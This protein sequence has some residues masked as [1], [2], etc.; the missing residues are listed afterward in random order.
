MTVGIDIGGTNT[1]GAIVGEDITTFKVP[2]ELGLG[3]ILKRICERID[4]KRERLVIST[5]LPLNLLLSRLEEYPTLTL[6]FPGPGLNYESYGVILKGAV[7][8]RGDVVE[9]LDEDQIREVL[10]SGKGRYKNVAIAGKFSIRNPLLELKTAKIV[11]DYYGYEDMALSFH[12]PELNYSLRINTTIVNAKIKRTVCELTKLIK[13]Y[14]EDFFYY[15]G[16]GGIVPYEIALDNPSLLYNSSPASVA[17][18]AYYLTGEKN[19]L[20]IDIGGTTTDFVQLVDG[21]PRIAEKV[22]VAGM[23][24]LIRCVES[25]SIPFGGD[26][27]V[28][29]G[30]L[31]PK[32]LDK[33]I[34]FGGEFFTLTDALNCMG[35]EI[36]DYRASREKG[37]EIFGDAGEVERIVEDYV[38][39]VAESVKATDCDRVIGTGYLARYLLPMIAKKAGVSYI[40]PEHSEAVNAIGVAV[41]RISLTM[42]ARFDTERGVAVFNGDVERF[43]KPFPEDEELIEIAKERVRS[44]AIK[45]GASEEDVKDVRVL[46]FNSF[47]VVRGGVKR[48]K[49]ADVVVQIEPGISVEFGK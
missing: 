13:R 15:R 1:D 11:A 2:N 16:D 43:G 26:S 41:S 17:I 37:R 44:E 34:A 18:G 21:K 27:V 3:E 30:K 33:P 36:G 48:G 28:E 23:K 25:F 38:S 47:T 49:I 46:Y 42:Y 9:E 24:T 31:R 32:R 40:V 8:H 6:L 22:V 20:V 7:N 35:Y 12:I 5:S 29:N 39:M 14:S 45:H 19:A 10:E 4:L